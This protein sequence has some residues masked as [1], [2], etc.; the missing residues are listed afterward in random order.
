MPA[1]DTLFRRLRGAIIGGLLPAILLSAAAG[2]W[3]GCGG[4]SPIPLPKPQKRPEALPKVPDLELRSLLLLLADRRLYEPLTVERAFDGDAELRRELAVTLGR[5]Q[6]RAGIPTL[7]A[8]LLDDEPKVRREAAFSLGLLGVD[9]A[10]PQLLRVATGED[11]EA[12]VLAVE[13]LAAAG[14]SVLDVGEAL[15]VLESEAGLGQDE[16]WQ[17]LLPV[18]YRFSGEP[19]VALARLGLEQAPTDE[20]K[21]WAVY[22]LAQDPQPRVA[23]DLRPLVADENPWIRGLAA[24]A[25]GRIGDGGDLELLAP[26]LRD[27]DPWVVIQTLEAGRR[28]V[29]SARAAALPSWRE[30][31]A[32]RLVDPRPGVRMA[33]IETS[34]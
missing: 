12:A 8:L 26:G 2:V 18:L 34:A 15:A 7:Q 1:M 33:A 9:S 27:P 25:L 28:L 22:A 30:P 32:E 11:R 17:R 4:A 23:A 31:L 24:Q 6:E 20:L 13:A 10:R 3:V 19:S 14:V 5:I 29:S 16:V 21:A